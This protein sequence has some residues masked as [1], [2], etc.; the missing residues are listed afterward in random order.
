MRFVKCDDFR[1]ADAI[2]AKDVQSG[3]DGD[4]DLAAAVFINGADVVHGTR[5]ARVCDRAGRPGG[6]FFNEFQ[7][8]AVLLAFHIDGVDKI[9]GTE[10]CKSLQKRFIDLRLA[11]G[12]PTVAG[13]VIAVRLLAATEIEHEI[14]TRDGGGQFVEAFHGKLA[15]FENV[16]RDDD[17]S[18]SCGEPSGGVRWRDAAADLQVAWMD[19]QCFLRRR[20]VAWAEHDDMA[21]DKPVAEIHVR[22]MA[23]RQI[24]DEIRLQVIVFTVFKRRSD[25]LLY[26]ASMEV[27]ARSESHV[28]CGRSRSCGI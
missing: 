3:A 1:I 22:I 6:E 8:N 13:D 19:G 2:A 18:G 7:F 17:F 10:F 12:L 23:R 15:V 11:D 21:A 24:G 27:D 16:R 28:S 26:F 5:S 9:F 20:V 14:F 25:D 4:I